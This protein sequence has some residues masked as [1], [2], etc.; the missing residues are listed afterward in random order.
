MLSSLMA[1]NQ[2]LAVSSKLFWV[3]GFAFTA[4]DIVSV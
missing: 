4:Y 1:C 2:F 3:F